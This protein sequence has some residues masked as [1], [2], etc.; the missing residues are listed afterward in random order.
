[1][2][3]INSKWIQDL[4]VKLEIIKLPEENISSKLLD[5]GLGKDFSNLIP[6]AKEKIG[7]WDLIKLSTFC[8]ANYQQNKKAC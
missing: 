1:M 2:C 3:K 8:T 4:Y 5:I 6:K 7:K